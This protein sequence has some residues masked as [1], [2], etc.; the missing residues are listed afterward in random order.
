MLTTEPV[1]KCDG[2]RE[3][4]LESLDT[5]KG[6]GDEIDQQAAAYEL[7]TGFFKSTVYSDPIS[8]H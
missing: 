3:N 4:R 6:Y 1:L 8:P 7:R 5:S 2:G